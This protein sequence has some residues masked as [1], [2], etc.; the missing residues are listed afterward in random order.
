MGVDDPF[1]LL[2]IAPSCSGSGPARLGSQSLWVCSGPGTQRV[3][4]TSALSDSETF[5]PALILWNLLLP[6]FVEHGSG[7]IPL[8][9]L[10]FVESGFGRGPVWLGSS[11]SGPAPAFHPVRVRLVSGSLLI[12]DP[13]LRALDCARKTLGGKK[14]QQVD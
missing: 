11:V 4:G 9:Q 10:R 12:I 3:T 5:C 8:V 2:G 7:R 13:S 6:S 1:R 14:F